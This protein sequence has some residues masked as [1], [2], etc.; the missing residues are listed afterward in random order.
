MIDY[1]RLFF[2][3]EQQKTLRK[4]ER[5]SA[6]HFCYFIFLNINFI[7]LYFCLLFLFSPCTRNY[8]L[9][10]VSGEI[11][12]QVLFTLSYIQK[13]KL[14]G[15]LLTSWKTCVQ[16]V[17]SAHPNSRG[18]VFHYGIVKPHIPLI[19]RRKCY[20]LLTIQHTQETLHHMILICFALFQIL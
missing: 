1:Q 8:A 7:T 6:Y 4:S 10:L 11:S 17:S 9:W 15:L 3:G 20:I 12:C 5:D 18:E 2:Y 13:Y 19:N 14:W 16:A